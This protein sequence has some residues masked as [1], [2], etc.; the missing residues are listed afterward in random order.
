M[1]DMD[2]DIAEEEHVETL[3]MHTAEATGLSMTR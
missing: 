1:K 3:M 2:E